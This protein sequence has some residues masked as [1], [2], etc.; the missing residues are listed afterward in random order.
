MDFIMYFS[1]CINKCNRLSPGL[2]LR[3]IH[4]GSSMLDLGLVYSDLSQKQ[5]LAEFSRNLFDE[6]YRNLPQT[7][8][9]TNK[10]QNPKWIIWNFSIIYIFNYGLSRIGKYLS[11]SFFFFSPPW[12]EFKI[13]NMKMTRLAQA[14]VAEILPIEGL[15]SKQWTSE[16]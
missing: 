9:Q 2:Q 15:L 1:S 3:S 8:K 14:V 6:M 7:G 5:H 12:E 11:S 16:D 13:E 10:Q 4:I